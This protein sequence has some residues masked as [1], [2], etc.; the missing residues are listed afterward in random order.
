MDATSALQQLEHRLTR[1]EQGL[2]LDLDAWMGDVQ[3]VLLGIVA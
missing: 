2:M 3:E 1:P